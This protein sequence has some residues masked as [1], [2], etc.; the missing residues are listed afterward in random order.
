MPLPAPVTSAT[1]R[2]G[3]DSCS[4]SFARNVSRFTLKPKVRYKKLDVEEDEYV[5]QADFVCGVVDGR[6]SGDGS[7]NTSHD[8]RGGPARDIQ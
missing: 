2:K 7:F 6:S 1:F 5:G 8:G 4:L 3:M